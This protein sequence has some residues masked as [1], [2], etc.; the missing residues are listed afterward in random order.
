MG[1]PWSGT[2]VVYLYLYQ[3][4]V[5]Y[6]HLIKDKFWNVTLISPISCFEQEASFTYLRLDRSSSL[7]L[8]DGRGTINI[9]V[10]STGHL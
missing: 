5:T 7:V 3:T 10:C 1:E 6:M 8:A 2:T 4:V 9:F